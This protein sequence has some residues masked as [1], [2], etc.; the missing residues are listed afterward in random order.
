M[1]SKAYYD[2][3]HGFFRRFLRFI[4]TGLWN[5]NNLNFDNMKFISEAVK[6]R[7]LIAGF[8]GTNFI[9]IHCDVE[10]YHNTIKTTNRI[11]DLNCIKLLYAGRIVNGKI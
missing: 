1:K 7:Y 8:H 2:L 6:Q 4:L 11:E 9:V 10:S 5:F 3:K